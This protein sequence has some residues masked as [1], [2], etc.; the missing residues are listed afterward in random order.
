MQSLS[1]TTA[2]SWVDML[3]FVMCNTSRTIIRLS[4]ANRKTTTMTLEEFYKATEG[5]P[6]DAEIWADVKVCI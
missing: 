6:K 3:R 4:C 1:F 2:I 5:M